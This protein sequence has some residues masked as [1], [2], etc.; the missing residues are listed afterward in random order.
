MID[1]EYVRNT[2]SLGNIRRV[3]GRGWAAGAGPV[4]GAFITV[5]CLIV[6]AMTVLGGLLM[7]L[8]WVAIGL[9]PNL[10]LSC[11]HAGGCARLDHGERSEFPYDSSGDAL[12][13]VP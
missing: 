9:P 5:I 11:S 7:L 3:G 12:Q 10:L 13:V 8:Q 2:I 6:I 4:L 1:I